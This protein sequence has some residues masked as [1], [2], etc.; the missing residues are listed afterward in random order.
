MPTVLT[1]RFHRALQ[2][3]AHI[4]TPDTRKGTEIP[5]IS[6][7]LQVAGLVLEFGGTED[8]AIAALLHDAAEDAGGE[9]ILQFI[10]AEFGPA[11]AK[12]V[13]ENSDSLTAEKTQKAPWRQRKEQYIAD[14]AHKSPSGL[15]VSICDKIHNARSLSLDSR[16]LGDTHWNR[17]NATQADSLWYYQSLVAAFESRIQDDPRLKNATQLL[18]QEVNQL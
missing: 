15:L 5:Y 11:I 17:F 10:E 7:L 6:H 18:R 3:A 1:H 16:T 8:E 12:I 4:H 13:R 2:F 9:P 14:I